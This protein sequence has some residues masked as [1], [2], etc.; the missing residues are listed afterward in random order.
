MVLPWGAC[1]LLLEPNSTLFVGSRIKSLSICILTH[2]GIV[3]SL[4]NRLRTGGRKHRGNCNIV[5]G[6]DS[7]T[8][9]SCLY[10]ALW[11]RVDW[12]AGILQLRECHRCVR[13]L[14]DDNW[15]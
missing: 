5:M 4:I 15:S 14:R 12:N 10:G 13:I 6:S 1:L 9:R 7:R 11:Q 3:P 8:Q 2:T